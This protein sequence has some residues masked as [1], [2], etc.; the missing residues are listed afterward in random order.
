[1]AGK[2]HKWALEAEARLPQEDR[3]E[4]SEPSMYAV[5]LVVL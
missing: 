3:L 2:G 4:T 1:M 5:S